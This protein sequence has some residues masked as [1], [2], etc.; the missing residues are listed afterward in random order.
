MGRNLQSSI[1]NIEIIPLAG[2]MV[3]NL[4]GP[5]AKIRCKLT[6]RF[7]GGRDMKTSL[8]LLAV[9]VTLSMVTLAQSGRR[10]KIPQIPPAEE[11]T[12]PAKPTPTPQVTAEKNESYR[13]TDDGTLARIIEPEK[14]SEQ[15]FTSKGVD[16]RADVYSRPNPK[17][18]K[19]ATKAGIQGY[20]ILKVVMHSNGELGRIRVVRS[21]P[22]GLTES[23]IRAACKIKFRPAQKD[24]KPV[25]QEVMIE[26]SFRLS[27]SSIYLP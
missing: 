26:Y 2:L 5:P 14:D 21:L 8:L 27:D 23:A 15:I 18:T 7:G 1:F 10:S 24:G 19:E 22:A 17:Y 6:V 16:L 13:C 12:A 11:P 4:H 9:V 3:G 20:V 25:T